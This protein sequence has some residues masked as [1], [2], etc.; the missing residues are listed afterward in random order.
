[1]YWAIRN[2]AD[3]DG[4]MRDESS[5]WKKRLRKGHIGWTADR[6]ASFVD[7]A[8]VQIDKVVTWA[9][10]S[11]PMDKKRM[12]WTKANFKNQRRV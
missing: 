4:S 1:M 3:P 2:S 10:G 5:K 7:H 6:L 11:E 12:T 8:A 9:I